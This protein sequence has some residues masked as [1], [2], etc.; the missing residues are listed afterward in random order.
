MCECTLAASYL[1]TLASEPG[2]AG[3]EAEGKEDEK[4][5]SAEPRPLLCPLCDTNS[6]SM[7]S[8][9]APRFISEMV[10]R[11][12]SVRFD[13]SVREIFLNTGDSRTATSCD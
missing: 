6:R 13:G 7:G 1:K 5:F 12:I 9:E 11:D 8:I 4:I 2:S 3:T 10:R